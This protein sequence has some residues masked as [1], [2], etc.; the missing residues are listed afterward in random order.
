MDYCE[1]LGIFGTIICPLILDLH[2]FK[3]FPLHFVSAQQQRSTILG[4]GDL[5][6]LSSLSLVSSH[7]CDLTYYQI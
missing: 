7:P 2:P 5:L 6:R 3:T 4:P 1:D